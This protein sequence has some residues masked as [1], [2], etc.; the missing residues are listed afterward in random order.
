M[1]DRL[2]AMRAGLDT[3]SRRTAA[4]ALKALVPAAAANA[5]AASLW[6]ASTRVTDLDRQNRTWAD[7]ADWRKKNDDRLHDAGFASALRIQCR[8]LQLCLEVDTPEKAG[9]AFPAIV[10]LQD[11]A[12]KVIPASGQYASM[13]HDGVFDGPVAKR[14]AVTKFCPQDW[15]KSAL[16]LDGH[17]GRAVTLAIAS[18]P[19]LGA[20]LVGRP[21]A[22]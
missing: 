16:D 2:R 22:P 8:Y 11:E 3:E 13:L 10:A 9:R 12:I 20:G 1:L 19:T 21:A 15:P 14:F 6:R 5:D 18:D 4:E 7:F 17:F